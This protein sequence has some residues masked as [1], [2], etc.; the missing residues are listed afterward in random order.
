MSRSSR[1]AAGI[2]TGVVILAFAPSAIFKLVRHPMAVE[3]FAKM[4]IPQGAILPIGL[5]ELACLVV[6]LI[7]RTAVLGALLLTGYLG[8]ATLANIIAG[9]DFIHALA[10][11]LLV[12]AGAWLRVPELRTL[13]PVRKTAYPQRAAATDARL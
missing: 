12:W 4:G 6:F 1:W 11:G 2:L 7:P 10:V 9:T 8:G 3:G 13:L 5:V